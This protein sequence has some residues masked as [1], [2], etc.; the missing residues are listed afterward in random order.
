MNKV[1]V[2]ENVAAK[3]FF[4]IFLLAVMIIPE[5]AF[6]QF[7]GTFLS[8]TQNKT[9]ANTVTFGLFCY[10]GYTWFSFF[11]N[12]ELASAFMNVLKPAIITFLA[13]KWQEALTF[14]FKK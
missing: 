13:F 6:A 3:I 1:M 10:A 11:S 12:F 2:K 14:F 7:D 8:I 5:L 4:G 9:F